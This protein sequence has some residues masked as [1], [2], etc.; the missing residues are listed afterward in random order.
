MTRETFLTEVRYVTNVNPTLQTMD[1]ELSAK[2]TTAFSA[3]PWVASVDAVAVEPPG[4]VNVKL[5]FRKPVLAVR[6]NDGVRAVDS[7]GVLLPASANT[8]GLPEL[9]TEVSPP[10]APGQTWPDPL[11]PRAASLAAEYLPRTLE[12]TEQG[13]RL[14]QPDGRILL[15][16]R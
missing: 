15:V 16:G 3:H 6:V 14:V 9:L 4:V 2:L 8:V 12:R 5:T 10:A 11:V 7:K 1:A 13:W